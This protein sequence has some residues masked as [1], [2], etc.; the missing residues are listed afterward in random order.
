MRRI[1]TKK[2]LIKHMLYYPLRL[3]PVGGVKHKILKSIL[4]KQNSLPMYLVAYRGD[5]IV[6][7]GTPNIITMRR[8]SRLVSD[9]GRVIVIEADPDNC[10]KLEEY[11]KARKMANVTIINKGGWSVSGVMMLAK[12]DHYD[13]D[14]KICTQGVEIDN[15]FRTTYSNHVEI[16]V[17][18]ID[19]MLDSIGVES[20]N[21]MAITVNGAELEVLKG[22][23]NLISKSDNLVV[24]AKGHAR[25]GSALTG[26]P[27][28]G[29]IKKYLDK[30]GMSSVVTYGESVSAEIEGWDRRE[31]DVV[32][33]KTISG[34]IR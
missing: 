22:C 26:E 12:S 8:Y 2:M 10:S 9:S 23:E 19:N 30:Q 1:Y 3:F 16:A 25:K 4:K 14:H 6:Q 13:G 24:Y 31:G 5:T 17:D 33:W 34:F 20:V 15:D 27:L 28:N 32:A 11:R 21:Y 29:D 18:T 7:V